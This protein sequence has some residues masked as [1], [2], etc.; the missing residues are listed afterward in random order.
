MISI[1]TTTVSRKKDALSMGK[2]LLENNLIVCS[3]VNKMTSQY[4]WKGKFHEESEYEITFKTTIAK[5]A[6][7]I[8]FIKK[9]HPYEVPCIASKESEVSNAYRAWMDQM[10]G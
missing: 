2:K 6:Q 10:I 4:I 1:I 8:K 9:H 7:T 5:K 3:N